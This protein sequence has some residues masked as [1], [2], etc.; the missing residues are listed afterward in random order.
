MQF[1]H[2]QNGTVYFSKRSIRK[3]DLLSLLVSKQLP[4]FRDKLLPIPALWSWHA[5]LPNNW[6]K[7][8]SRTLLPSRC[9]CV[10][11]FSPLTLLLC[12][13]WMQDVGE[14]LLLGCMCS[15]HGPGKSSVSPHKF[16]ECQLEQLT[17]S[18]KHRRCFFLPRKWS[19]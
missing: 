9:S 5:L 3:H 2:G 8:T 10:L 19:L 14:I 16:T 11:G 17:A 15:G 4:C 1:A 7:L 6:T 13:S 18:Y 12:P